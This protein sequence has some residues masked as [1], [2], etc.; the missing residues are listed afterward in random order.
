[1]I[2]V[3]GGGGFLG[4]NLARHLLDAGERVLLLD[5]RPFEVPSFLV[6]FWDNQVRGVVGELL[7]LP[8]LLSIIEKHSVGSIIHAAFLAEGQGTL[9]Q[10]LKVNVEGTINILEAC[11]IFGLRRFTFISSETV[12]FGIKTTVAF[13]EDMDL[14]VKSD[15]FI[16]AVKK[17]DEQVCLLY[18]KQYGLSVPIIR[19]ARIY[20]PLYHSGRIPVQSMIES[21]VTGKPVDLSHIYGGS[22]STY[23]YVKDC[24]K[25]IS[26]VHLAGALEHNVYNL[27]DGTSHSYLDFAQ[28]IKEIIPDADIRFGKTR[29]EKDIDSPLLD[30]EQIKTEMG[31]TPNYDL[32]RGV[33]DYIDWVRDKKY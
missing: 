3:T 28:A 22:K 20:G 21:A 33:R 1:M 25:G 6:P 8:H 12:Y 26:L 13:N 11:R 23:I 10:G 19:P 32:R 24:S 14:P 31:F 16:Q 9:Y 18:A 4:F 27:G 7:D 17:A 15:G 29:S 5:N 30:I 2:L